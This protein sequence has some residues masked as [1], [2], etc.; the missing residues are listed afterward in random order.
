MIIHKVTFLFLIIILV[1]CNQQLVW[2]FK[3][4]DPISSSPSISE[5][6]VFFGSWDGYLYCLDVNTGQEIWKFGSDQTT[7]DIFEK[8]IFG[9]PSISDGKV[10]FGSTDNYLYC[11]DINTGQE[12]W[13]FKTEHHVD[14][15][16]I[17]EGKVFF[18]SFD[19]YLYC[20]DVTTGKQ[21]WKFKTKGMPSSPSISDGK[22]FY[23]TLQIVNFLY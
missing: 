10:L 12:I 14:D 19:G 23:E 22:V 8:V 20:V 11:V 17:S 16:S 4:Q 18:G 15:P 6:K 1:G 21:I 5:G 13:K 9:S 7:L 2:K 3:T